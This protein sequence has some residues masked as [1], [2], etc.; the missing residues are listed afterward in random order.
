MDMDTK[1]ESALVID[2]RICPPFL[3]PFNLGTTFSLVIRGDPSN[4]SLE[5]VGGFSPTPISPS[6]V[7]S[8]E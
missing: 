2:E 6:G 7:S 1:R 8:P 3:L 4:L 5:K